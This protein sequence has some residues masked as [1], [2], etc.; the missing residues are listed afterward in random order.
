MIYL[1]IY[2]LLI[3][4][5]LAYAIKTK[6]GI[7]SYFLWGLYLAVSLF[8]LLGGYM[9]LLDVNK[10]TLLPFVF[11]F[12]NYLIFF[13]PFMSKKFDS[14]KI[15]L[16]KGKYGFLVAFL[17]IYIFNAALAVYCYFP[18]IKN[19]IASGEWLSTLNDLYQGDIEFPYS[20]QIEHIAI[21]FSGYF[22]LLALITSFVFISNNKHRIISYV[23][24]LL[25]LARDF[26]GS[27]YVS[28]RGMIVKTILLLIV[29]IF[30]FFKSFEKRD[31]RI[32]LIVFAALMI[33]FVPYVSAVTISRFSSE[34]SLDSLV[35]YFGL[36]PIAFNYGVFNITSISW[37]R[38][39]WGTLFGANTFNQAAVGGTWGSSFYSFVG[40]LYID[41]GFLGTIIIGLIVMY[42]FS[43]MVNKHKYALSEVFIL[44][45]YLGFLLEG[46]FVIGRTY[47]ISIIFT[48]LVFIVLKFSENVQIYRMGK[49]NSLQGIS[50]RCLRS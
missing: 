7:V 39:G 6:T 29:L 44:F 23:A 15:S 1:W 41:W 28:S 19:L 11:L 4:A 22:S 14:N 24:I 36:A 3:L 47:N 31:K 40:W 35:E 21:L 8:S 18:H 5:S 9:K 46:V 13:R 25:S 37:G 32:I 30:F 16:Y 27:I 12:V 42:I 45:F 33:A 2:S 34:K 38:F 10:I 50:K 43:R 17:L 49:Y 20:N 26:V 48:V